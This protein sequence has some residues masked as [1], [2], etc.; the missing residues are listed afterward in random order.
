MKKLIIGIIIIIILVAGGLFFLPNIMNALSPKY[1]LSSSGQISSAD[2]MGPKG[3][4]QFKEI[5]FGNNGVYSVIISKY[6]S[7]SR[8]DDG[9]T[10][11]LA[12]YNAG[13]IGLGGKRVYI[14]NTTSDGQQRTDEI[15]YYLSGNNIVAIYTPNGTSD[16]AKANNIDFVEWYITKYIPN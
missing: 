10:N 13:N 4:T 3:D 16:E 15:Y 7:S 14:C 9:M 11:I 8:A 2:M 5:Y 1:T 12:A 6:T